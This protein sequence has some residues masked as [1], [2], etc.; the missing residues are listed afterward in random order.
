MKFSSQVW[1]LRLQAYRRRARRLTSG[2]D[3]L[4]VQHAGGARVKSQ[5]RASHFESSWTV[6]GTRYERPGGFDCAIFVQGQCQA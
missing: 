4:P 6:V 2:G 1:L 5:S 3:A